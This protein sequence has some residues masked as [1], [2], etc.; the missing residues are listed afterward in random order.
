MPFP[1]NIPMLFYECRPKG[2]SFLI[3]RHN[4][5]EWLGIAINLSFRNNLYGKEVLGAPSFG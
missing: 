4:L 3:Q 2:P 5:H 1:Q